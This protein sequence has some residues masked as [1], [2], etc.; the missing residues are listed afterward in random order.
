MSYFTS[1][2]SH[3]PQGRGRFTDEVAG[4]ISRGASLSSQEIARAAEH[5]AVLYRRAAM[6]FD[7]FDVLICPATQVRP[8]PVEIRW[9]RGIDGQECESYVDWIM[10][11]YAWSVLGCPALTVPLGT[12]EDG[13]PVAIQIVGPPHSEARLLSVGAWIESEVRL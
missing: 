13:L 4:D 9:P 5:R 1:W 2:G 3:W 6:F 7:T 12:D 11:T 10:I 8:F